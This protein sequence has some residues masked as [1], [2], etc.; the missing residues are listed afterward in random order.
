M[1]ENVSDSNKGPRFMLRNSSI[2]A[3]DS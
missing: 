2:T 3:P 1:V